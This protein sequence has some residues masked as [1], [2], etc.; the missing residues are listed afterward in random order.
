MGI[1]EVQGAKEA[2]A[3]QNPKKAGG[4]E[5]FQESLL[6]NLRSKKQGQETSA[7]IADDG[8][9]TKEPS[10]AARIGV[11]GGVRVN[12]AMLTEA[13]QAAKVRHMRYEESDRVEIA[14]TDGYA[15]KGKKGDRVYVEAK[16]EDGRIEAYQVDVERIPQ[17]TDHLIERFAL[18]TAQKRRQL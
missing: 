17:N 7:D 16:Y 15:L 2:P 8:K 5:G 1:Q 9:R 11:T 4:G 6:Q 12:A 18:D 3:Y 14:V 10:E 13:V